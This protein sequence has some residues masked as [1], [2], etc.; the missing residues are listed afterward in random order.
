MSLGSQL[1]ALRRRV[2]HKCAICQ[3]EFT[4][5][6]KARYCSNACRQKAAYYRRKKV[7]K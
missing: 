4:A 1:A 6:S 5:L 2:P 3:K 7:K